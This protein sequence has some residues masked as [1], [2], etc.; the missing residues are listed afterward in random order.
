MPRGFI[1]RLCPES[2]AETR[3]VNAFATRVFRFVTCQ[4]A[5]THLCVI[6]DYRKLAQDENAGWIIWTPSASYYVYLIFSSFRKR[7]VRG[8]LRG[9]AWLLILRD[10]R[11]IINY[12]ALL[13]NSL[14]GCC[15]SC[16]VNST[17]WY[18]LLWI[19]FDL[20]LTQNC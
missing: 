18:S 16:W 20:F 5:C 7:K 13:F 17:Y 1:Q 4:H 3:A 19:L 14:I 2:W 11:W 12:N 8:K 6:S 9:T 15:I 10:C